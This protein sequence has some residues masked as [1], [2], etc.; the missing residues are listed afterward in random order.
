MDKNSINNF[1]STLPIERRSYKEGKRYKS[2]IERDF[3]F[4][5][6]YIKLYMKAE[7]VDKELRNLTT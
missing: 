2:G 3:S 4:T 5:M 1:S 6:G 7:G